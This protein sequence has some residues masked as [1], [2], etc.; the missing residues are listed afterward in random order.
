MKVGIIGGGVFGS[1]IG[2][3]LD[4]K[5]CDVTIYD[6]RK[7]QAASL[8]SG[9][10]MKPSWFGNMSKEDSAASLALLDKLYGLQ[11]LK[12]RIGPLKTTV[13]RVDKKAVLENS[14]LKYVEK[15]VKEIHDGTIILDEDEREYDLV[16]VAAGVWCKRFFDLDGLAGKTGVSFEWTQDGPYSPELKRNLISVWAPYKQVVAFNI[17]ESNKIWAG[18][19]TAILEKN[20]EDV[21]IE[22]CQRRICKVTGLPL[23]GGSYQVGIRPFYKT[24]HPCHVEKRGHKMWLATGGSKNGTIGAGWAANKIRESL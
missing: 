16:V 24:K 5:G 4:R 10:L 6:C 9:F 1:V 19:G 12:F 3:A 13:Y 23:N 14:K 2:A 20:W 17:P 15:K 7:Q 8:A 21:R 11:E 22:D 18:D